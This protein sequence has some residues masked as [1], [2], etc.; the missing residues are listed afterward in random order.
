[1]PIATEHYFLLCR[2]DMISTAAMQTVLAALR[3]PA[4]QAELDCL[5][6]Y[7]PTAAGTATALAQ[8]YPALAAGG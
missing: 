7:D 4:F 3:D 2:D 8:A 6:G 1:M 5:P